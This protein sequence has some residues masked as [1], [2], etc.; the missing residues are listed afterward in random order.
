MHWCVLLVH[1]IRKLSPWQRRLCVEIVDYSWLGLELPM[2]RENW[3]LTIIDFARIF[4]I[5]KCNFKQQ[6][7][8]LAYS[9]SYMVIKFIGI[10]TV[11][12]DSQLLADYHCHFHAYL[13]IL[14]VYAIDYFIN[15]E[16]KRMHMH[17][18]WRLYTV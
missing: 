14:S 17:A 4:Y 10:P 1:P 11:F 7:P 18:R 15:F 12:D 3:E 9:V 13:M 6:W 8:S 2:K 16:N 5:G